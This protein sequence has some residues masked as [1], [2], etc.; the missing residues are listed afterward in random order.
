MKF[1]GYEVALRLTTRFQA[2]TITRSVD[3]EVHRLLDAF[4]DPDQK[5]AFW[6]DKWQASLRVALIFLALN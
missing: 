6:N 4:S 1:C 2:A 3:P 5:N